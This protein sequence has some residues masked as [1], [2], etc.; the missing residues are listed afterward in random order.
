MATA[1]AILQLAVP[2]VLFIILL[3]LYS[4]EVN[5]ISVVNE[6]VTSVSSVSA[7]PGANYGTVTINT[8]GS[9]AAAENNTARDAEKPQGT[10]PGNANASE[11]KLQH[12]VYVYD[13]GPKYTT[14]VL[15][16]N[17]PWYDIQYDGDKYITKV[18]L[19]SDTIRT[20][21]PESATLFYVPF[22]AA[23]FTLYYFKNSDLNMA[24]AV[25]KT[26]QVRCALHCGRILQNRRI[27][28][29]E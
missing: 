3:L 9:E 26:S 15:A 8:S 10:F 13:L 18:L 27:Q 14:D 23:R 6:F 2:A 11:L 4:S 12:F 28:R 21:D 16:L 7:C 25:N 17:P 20:M 24:Y 1:T 29:W 5:V 19:E 22:F